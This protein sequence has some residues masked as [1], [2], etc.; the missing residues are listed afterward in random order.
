M[1]KLFAVTTTAAF[2]LSAAGTPALAQEEKVS[3]SGL[4]WL[5]RNGDKVAGADEP[6]LAGEKVVRI[7]KSGGE[8]VGEYT[9]DD[10][11]VYSA[12]D[13]PAGKYHVN[14]IRSRYLPTGRSSATTEGG[15]V[16]FGARGFGIAGHSFFDRNK[17]G[18]RQADED[19]LSPGT[20]NGKPIAVSRE[21]GAFSVDDLPAGDYE[22]VAADYTQRGLALVEPKG[23]LPIDWATGTLRFKLGELEGPGPLDAVYFEARADIAV[24]AAVTPVKKTYTVGDRIDVE[25]T[26]S[27]KGDVPVTP[28]VVMAEFAVKLL[29]HSDNV[30][31]VDGRD[32]DFETTT[33]ILPGQQAVVTFQVELNDVTFDEVWPIVRF[34][35]G[36][37]KD[38]DRKN[39][40]VRLPVEV[41]EKGAE[42]TAPTTTSET[43]ATAAPAT[44]TTQVVAQAGSRSGLA[45]TGASPLG[46]IGLGALLLAA[47]TSAFLIARRRRS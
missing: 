45:S 14:F 15:T 6:G 27:N 17:D 13:L 46:F 36:H 24:A 18:L 33:K 19:L 3:I 21:D 16:D 22:F 25:V 5:D 41:V 42:T 40:V 39:N 1:K 43:S 20:L 47:G 23:T 34:N 9:T 10:K 28:S 12:K 44:T 29:K 8:L 30:K 38:V 7:T 2:V 32:D 11:G 35:F 37:L 26:L 31:F 4:V